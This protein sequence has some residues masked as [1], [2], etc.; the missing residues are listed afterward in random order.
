MCVAGWGVLQPST[1]F[2]KFFIS[3]AFCVA[4]Y[5]FVV[6]PVATFSSM[7]NCILSKFYLKNS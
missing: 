4:A 5:C 6:E 1:S 2:F 7:G 3:V